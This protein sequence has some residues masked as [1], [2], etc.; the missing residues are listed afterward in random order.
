MIT[1][2][3]LKT[4]NYLF[5]AGSFIKVTGTVIRDF[6]LP[7][8][9]SCKDY[10]PIPLTPEILEKAGF[11]LDERGYK[12][13]ISGS[14]WLILDEDEGYNIF[15]LQIDTEG[16][17]DYVLLKGTAKSVHQLQNLYFALTG[18]ELTIEL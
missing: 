8:C 2:N 11:V 18:E 4:G 17:I 9:K 5:K 13:P 1:A 6:E 7:F 3:E 15:I 10:S 16:G 12:I 14:A